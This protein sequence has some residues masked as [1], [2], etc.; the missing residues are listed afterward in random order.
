MNL[1][2]QFFSSDLLW[3]TNTVF[4]ILLARAAWF[5]PWKQVLG[6][7]IRTNALV[8]LT[9][10]VFLFWQLNAGFRPGYNHHIIGA[11]LFVLMFGWQAAFVVLSGIMLA[12][13]WR[14]GTPLVSLGINGLMMIAIPVY[15]S[16]WMLRLIR[17]HLPKN[18]FIFVLCNGFLCG[19]LSMA[20][21][22]ATATALLTGLSP[23]TWASVQR[24]YLIA[25]PIIIFAEAF[26][27]GALI[28]AFAVSKPEAVFNFDAD[29]YLTGK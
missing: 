5:A 2:A 3:L 21:V 14:A 15:F 29:E 13:W 16:E 10:G 20:L 23:N 7:Q 11:T 22:V 26:A 4:A 6:T 24:N 25:A 27:T 19:G 28:T 12:T 8:G 18:F 9:L 1:P 17:R